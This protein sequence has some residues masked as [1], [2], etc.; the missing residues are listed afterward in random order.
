MNSPIREKWWKPPLRMDTNITPVFRQNL[1]PDVI[2]STKNRRGDLS[3]RQPA[4]LSAETLLNRI[5]PPLEWSAQLKA[6]GIDAEKMRFAS[7]LERTSL[8]HRLAE[9]HAP[10]R[11]VTRGSAAISRL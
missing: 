7:R 9:M 10:R 11:R 1:N 3:G 2:Y 6:L 8:I 4:D 5:D